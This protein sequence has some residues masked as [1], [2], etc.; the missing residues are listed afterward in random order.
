MRVA[1]GGTYNLRYGTA[2]R[3]RRPVQ[4]TKK[5]RKA[6]FVL[7]PH[8]PLS[9]H[10]APSFFGVANRPPTSSG[11]AIS[12]SVGASTCDPHGLPANAEQLASVV[13]EAAD[14]AATAKAGEARAVHRAQD[15]ALEVGRAEQLAS[16]VAEAA[17]GAEARQ[18]TERASSV[19]ETAAGAE[20]GHAEHLAF[21]VAETTAETEA[22]PT[23][24]LAS[25]VAETAAEAGARHAEQLVSAV[26]ET[27][28]EVEARQS[29][30]CATAVAKAVP[31]AAARAKA[32]AEARH[33]K[34]LEMAPAGRAAARPVTKLEV[35]EPPPGAP[36]VTGLVAES[37][38]RGGRPAGEQT[39]TLKAAHAS[40][41]AVDLEKHL[42][43]I[44]RVAAR[45]Y[46]ALKREATPREERVAA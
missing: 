28:A 44:E 17:D 20:A 32:V 14:G 24:Q 4:I 3:D 6:L 39:Q 45:G 43:E 30:E 11:G 38:A 19:A 27:A 1:G 16:V 25:A 37:P 10:C 5:G 33:A 46:G 42:A 8:A 22:R 40:E 41:P 23:E 18:P 7:L 9:F 2:R 34:Q 12:Q 26:V 21:A 36:V 13:A 31:D 15:E 29:R 35:G